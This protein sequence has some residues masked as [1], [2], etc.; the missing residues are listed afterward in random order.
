MTTCILPVAIA[1]YTLSTLR[2]ENSME[3]DMLCIHKNSKPVISDSLVRMVDML[4]A[5]TS[6]HFHSLHATYV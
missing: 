6:R 4:V 1:T 3:T 5:S 2:A